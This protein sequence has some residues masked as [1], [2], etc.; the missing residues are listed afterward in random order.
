MYALERIRVLAFDCYGTLVDWTTGIQ[1]LLDQ[2]ASRQ[3][4][5]L[6]VEQVAREWE[7]IQFELL[8]DRYR[9]YREILTEATWHTLARWGVR[10]S[11]AEA[12]L[13]VEHLPRW[14]VFE[15]VPRV[16]PHLAQHFQLVVVSNID[17]DLLHQ[18]LQRLRVPF[19][20]LITAQQVQSYKP[21]LAH[22]LELLRRLQVG[23]EEVLHC[24]FGSRY[25]LRPAAA[26]GIPTVWIRR[27]GW[28]D[29]P[30]LGSTLQ[31]ANLEELAELLGVPVAVRS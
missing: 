16:L 9:P 26:L 30:E 23:P 6:P 19:A 18:T 3:G 28:S 21:Q 31:V 7:A 1:E 17:D 5:S 20:Q 11:P 10:L 13:I 22:F 2:L 8:C 29:P 15:D 24:A 12:V 4:L 25:D 14:P 27:P